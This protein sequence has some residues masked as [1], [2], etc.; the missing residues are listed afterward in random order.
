[1][2]NWN[3]KQIRQT[4][5]DLD[6]LSVSKQNLLSDNTEEFYIDRYQQII[7]CL[8]PIKKGSSV[9]DTG[10][11][12]GFLSLNIQ[13]FYKLKKLHTLEHP[14][15]FHNYTKR[16]L[17]I[18]SKN[19]ISVKSV[20]LKD[21]IYP[22]KNGYFDYIIFSEILEHL[23]PSEVPHVFSEFNRMLKKEGKLIVSTPNIASFLKRLNLFLFG[24]NPN[25]LDLR[26]D[27]GAVYGHIKEYTCD[28][29][30]MLAKP[31]FDVVKQTYISLDRKR[32]IYTELEYRISRV[33]PHLGNGFVIVFTKKT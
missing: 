24:K 6:G 14:A 8:P 18:M 31:N 21:E 25:Q 3:K 17:K 4:I 30:V 28:E 33:F 2:N 32:N 10:L 5:S 22:W 13:R 23:I 1:M 26:L 9:L 20:D 16:F 7:E 12:S 29:V 19:N 11:S 15:I 27:F